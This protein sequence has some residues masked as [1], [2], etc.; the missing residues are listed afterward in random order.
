ML[1]R[2]P[3]APHI[4]SFYIYFLCFLFILIA[5]SIE[6]TRT[7]KSTATTSP[8]KS[9]DAS[10]KAS[11]FDAGAEAAEVEGTEC[12]EYVT[13]ATLKQMHSIQEST[14]KSI[15]ESFIMSVN[16]RVDDLVKSVA[17]VKSSLEY[18]QRDV[19]DLG[20]MAAKLKDAE[21]EISSLQTDLRTQDSKLEYLE[22]QIRRNNIRISGIPESPDETWEVAEAKVKQAIQEQLGVDVDIERAHRVERRNHDRSSQDTQQRKPRTIVCKLRCWKQ[23]EAVLK[24]ARKSKPSGLFISEDLALATLQRRAAQV[25]K[26][27]EAKQAGKIAYFVLDRLIIRDKKIPSTV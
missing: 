3:R 10:K 20:K 14:L 22:N 5:L 6:M 27:R 4:T 13:L 17:E 21:E 24:K 18:T 7:K 12:E 26:L 2:A 19:V 8:L 15:F 16:L 11:K 25:G 1:S 23:R 9:Q